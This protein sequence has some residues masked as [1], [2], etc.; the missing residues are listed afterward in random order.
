MYGLCILNLTKWHTRILWDINHP[1]LMVKQVAKTSCGP[2]SRAAMFLLGLFVEPF[3][4]RWNP[5]KFQ[6]EGVNNAPESLWPFVLAGTPPEWVLWFLHQVFPDNLNKTGPTCSKAM[7]MCWGNQRRRM[8]VEVTGPE[9][10]L[11]ALSLAG[12][13]KRGYFLGPQNVST[14]WP[15]IFLWSRSTSTATNGDCV[16]N[17]RQDWC[18]GIPMVVDLDSPAW[19]IATPPLLAVCMLHSCRCQSPSSVSAPHGTGLCG[20]TNV[21]ARSFS[22]IVPIPCIRP[23]PIDQ[24]RLN[25]NL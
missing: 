2:P 16:R 4:L 10:H 21:I 22:L 23:Y 19:R 14:S 13:S 11:L 8:Q 6:W 12:E 24:E 1:K 3:S 5:L 20:Q 25:F 18:S 7:Q 17:T 9:P 15:G